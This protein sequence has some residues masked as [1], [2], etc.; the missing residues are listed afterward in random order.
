MIGNPITFKKSEFT[1]ARE[2]TGDTHGQARGTLTDYKQGLTG[3]AGLPP[4]HSGHH[5]PT[6]KPMEL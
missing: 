4:L 5:S 3:F 6:G 1:P 2:S